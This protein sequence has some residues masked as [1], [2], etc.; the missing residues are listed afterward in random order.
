MSETSTPRSHST[1]VYMQNEQTKANRWEKLQL[2]TSTDY[3]LNCA[4][5]YCCRL[6]LIDS[7]FVFATVQ[8]QLP[9]VTTA[10]HTQT[11]TRSMKSSCWHSPGSPMKNSKWKSA[12]D[13]EILISDKYQDGS[14]PDA[15]T[16]FV[17]LFLRVA[18]AFALALSIIHIFIFGDGDG[19]E[20]RSITV[21]RF[22]FAGSVCVRT[23]R[24]Q[25]SPHLRR[26]LKWLFCFS[27][28]RTFRRLSLCHTDSAYVRNVLVATPWGC[29]IETEKEPEKATKYK[30]NWSRKN[31]WMQWTIISLGV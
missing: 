27:S 9:V 14:R 26:K 25:N 23:V 15:R 28:I 11:H 10:Q 13:A 6:N 17:L 2:K 12:R 21:E 8:Q 30:K 3:V 18:F 4:Q 16:F 31:A 20:V 22:I 24:A 7:N 5:I 19:D 29:K 1:C